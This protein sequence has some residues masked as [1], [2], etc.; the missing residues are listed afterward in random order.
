LRQA[1]I[2]D[3]FIVSADL[4]QSMF[5]VCV[6]RCAQLSTYYHWIPVTIMA[7]K[8]YRKP[9]G[10]SMAKNM[11]FSRCI[12]DQNGVLLSSLEDVLGI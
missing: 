2:N 4:F 7:T 6:R 11:T 1:L 9:S 8:Y 3:F 12:K 10:V 5:D